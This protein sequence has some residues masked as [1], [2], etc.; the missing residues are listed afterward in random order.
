MDLYT[1]KSF[2]LGYENQRK[3]NF[4]RKPEFHFEIIGLVGFLFV[5][6]A[7]TNCDTLKCPERLSLN[8][9]KYRYPQNKEI[10]RDLLPKDIYVS[11]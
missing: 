7:L 9:H 3:A 6:I 5:K 4:C 1:S 10:L 11:P 8:D 2:T